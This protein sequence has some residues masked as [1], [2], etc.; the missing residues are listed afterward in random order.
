MELLEELERRV[1]LLIE[2]SHNLERELAL[3]RNENVQMHQGNQQ[4]EALVAELTAE[5][6]LLLDEKAVVKA[7]V[8][9][10]LQSIAAVE[11]SQ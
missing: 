8:D 9:D 6:Q 3:M 7:T 5:R 11:A 4:L 2:K 10:I 1:R